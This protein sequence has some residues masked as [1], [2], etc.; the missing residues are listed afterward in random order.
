MLHIRD[1]WWRRWSGCYATS[2]KVAE[3]FESTKFFQPHYGPG[4]YPVS[5]IYKYKENFPGVNRD[6]HVRLNNLTAICE[7]IVQKMWD[8]RDLTILQESTAH[9]RD[10]FTL[11]FYFYAPYMNRT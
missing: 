2:R 11:Y 9:N 3:V 1:T 4:V 5:N 7:P 8:P 10:R 6:R